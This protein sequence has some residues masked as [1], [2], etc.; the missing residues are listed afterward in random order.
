MIRG[1]DRINGV[2]K[3]FAKM[4]KQV[5]QGISE[6]ID[7]MDSNKRDIQVLNADNVAIQTE[8]DKAYSLGHALKKFVPS[9]G[10]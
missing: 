7:S 2:A 9:G 3:Q 10:K 6:L 1:I 5:E 4:L 8:L